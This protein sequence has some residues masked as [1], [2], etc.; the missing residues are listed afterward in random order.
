MHVRACVCVCYSDIIH[1]YI[2]IYIDLFIKME[3]KILSFR[4]CTT[5]L[6]GFLYNLTTI[7]KMYC[8][9]NNK[10]N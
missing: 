5:G 9:D 7:L 3:I 2:Y 4:L 6:S 10:N 1:T 8:T